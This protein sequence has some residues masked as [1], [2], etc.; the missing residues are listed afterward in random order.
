MERS[1]GLPLLLLLLLL[2]ASSAEGLASGIREAKEFGLTTSTKSY[3][4]E[5]DSVGVQPVAQSFLPRLNYT[6]PV[7]ALSSPMDSRLAKINTVTSSGDHAGHLLRSIKFN[8]TV[9]TILS[10]EHMDIKFNCSINVPK[11]L[12]NQ[13]FPLFTLWK[14]GKEIL[15]VG[16]I[17]SQYYQFDDNEIT[18]MKAAF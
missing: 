7:S 14:N 16:R 1:R 13:D 2:L 4:H 10:A 15:D 5:M 17:A 11:S 3:S 8:P 18:T 12:V 9:G 6:S